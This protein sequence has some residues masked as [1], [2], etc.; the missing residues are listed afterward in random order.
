MIIKLSKKSMLKVK[1]DQ[2]LSLLHQ[3]VSQVVNAKFPLHFLKF[4]KEIK[5]ATS[6]NTRM[7]ES[8]T[9]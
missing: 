7:M 1:T 4:F 3:T 2:K 5:N 6:V 9:A 8:K